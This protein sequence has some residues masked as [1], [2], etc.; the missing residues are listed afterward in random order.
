MDVL[1]PL[2]LKFLDEAGDRIEPLATDRF[3]DG[4]GSFCE[5]QL[6]FTCPDT[7]RRCFRIDKHTTETWGPW[8]KVGRARQ[9][10]EGGLQLLLCQR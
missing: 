7:L 4:K 10:I 6:D 9:W 3:V 1:A 2:W 5:A 8:S